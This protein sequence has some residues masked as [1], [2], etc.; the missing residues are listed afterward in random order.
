MRGRWA[1]VRYRWLL[2]LARRGRPH[3]RAYARLVARVEHATDPDR[4]RVAAERIARALGVTPEDAAATYRRCLASEAQEEADSVYFM[5]RPALAPA[6]FDIDSL[7]EGGTGGVG[8][9]YGTLHF[10]S[11]V[12]GYLGLCSVLD[13]PVTMVGRPLDDANPMPAAKRAYAKDKVRWVER[14]SGRAFLATDAAAMARAREELLAGRSLYTPIDVPGS[15]AGRAA[16]VRPFGEPIRLA[17]GLMT[18]ARLTGASVVPVV[19]LSRPTGFAVR[20]G[21]RLAPGAGGDALLEAAVAE[22]AGFVRDHPDEWW[23]WPY[24]EVAR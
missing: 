9:V 15:V 3:G 13:V 21:R 16:R 7:P 5:Q 17:S 4:S 14:L 8:T 22:L 20:F 10:G 1:E 23:M 2:P 18:L 24:L 19:A 11:P 6:L 12:F